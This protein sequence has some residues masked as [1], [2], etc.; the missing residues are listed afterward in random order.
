MSAAFPP[1]QFDD[2]VE[3]MPGVYLIKRKPKAPAAASADAA[4]AA[5]AIGMAPGTQPGGVMYGEV[6][7]SDNV[8]F[9]NQERDRLS[10]SIK[11]LVKSNQELR[12]ADPNDPDFTEAIAENVKVIEKRL[13]MIETIDRRIRELIGADVHRCGS[14]AAGPRHPAQEAQKQQ[15]QP[16]REPQ[17]HNQEQ[18]QTEAEDADDQGGVFL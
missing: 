15:Q 6:T 3:V 2:E 12:E 4:A 17:A 1:D 11:L 13:L 9:L 18:R 14:E 8:E 16:S 7:L 10:H 5:A